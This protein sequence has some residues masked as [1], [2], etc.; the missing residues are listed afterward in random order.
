[1]CIEQSTSA[2]PKTIA[3]KM[4]PSEKLHKV[5]IEAY[6]KFNGKISDWA[7]FE[8]EFNVTATL[9]GLGNVLCENTNQDI[10]IQSNDNYKKKC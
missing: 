2:K 5:K 10:L 9:Q 4:S 6:P 8:T 3:T 1:M 7:N